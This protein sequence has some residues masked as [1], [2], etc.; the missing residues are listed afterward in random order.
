MRFKR[1]IALAAV[2]SLAL[3]GW[4]VS[5][6][7]AQAAGVSVADGYSLTRMQTGINRP[8]ALRFAPDGRLF[9]LEQTGRVRI[10]KQGSMSTALTIDPADIVEPGGSAGLLSIAFPPTFKT[11][12]VQWVYLVYTHSPMSGFNYPHNV[13]SRFVINGDVIDPSSEQLLVHFDTLV[14]GDGTVKT[15]HYGGDMEFGS[16]GE[17][18]VSTGD[19][20]IG[21]NAQN[22]QNLYGKIL[23]YNP[24]GTIP[25][26][27]P[28]Y[29]TLNGR[30]RAIW[31]NGLRNPFKLAYD[32]VTGDILIGDVGSSTWEEVNKLPAGEPAVNFGWST[33]EGY[34]SDPRFRT[35][36]LAY[37][38]DP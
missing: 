26:D 8:H 2:S 11:D 3:L 1:A 12:A 30:L 19:L 35:P 16:D 24:N 25:T 17:L 20:L 27:N 34:T 13:L 14:G 33:T 7:P 18:Y 22:L 9:L 5:L 28:Y 32:K 10:V 4:V 15:M 38:H 23:R 37:P 29:N 36:L 31:S 6:P 21:P